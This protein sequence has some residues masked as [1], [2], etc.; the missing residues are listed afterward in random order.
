MSSGRFAAAVPRFLVWLLVCA[1]ELYLPAVAESVTALIGSLAGGWG[2]ATLACIVLGLLA[3]VAF[4]VGTAVL[5][6]RRGRLLQP[7]IETEPEWAG[8]AVVRTF[9]ETRA[10]ATVAV[11]FGGEATPFHVAEA[12]W[13]RRV[14]SLVLIGSRRQCRA[15]FSSRPVAVKAVDDGRWIACRRHSVLGTRCAFS[16]VATAVE[17]ERTLNELCKTRV[18][19]AL[20]HGSRLS[21]LRR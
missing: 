7:C 17:T 11:P 19:G 12:H 13:R 21:V 14:G 10:A 5:A 1:A 4:V 8:H 6:A 3:V 18:Y 9:G 2:P 15:R 16:A 20:D